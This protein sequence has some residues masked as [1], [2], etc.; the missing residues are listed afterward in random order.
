MPRQTTTQRN[1]ARAV[2]AQRYNGGGR[3]GSGGGG[4]YVGERRNGT[5][6]NSGRRNSQLG[7]REQ[8]RA[9]LRYAF[10]DAIRAAG[11]TTG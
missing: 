1:I 5:A 11:G 6:T 9:D 4:R 3:Y 2:G 10:R 7:T 8:K